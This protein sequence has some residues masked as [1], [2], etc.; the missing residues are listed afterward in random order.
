MSVV[1]GGGLAFGRGVACSLGAVCS[2]GPAASCPSLDHWLCV[3]G[4]R[5]ALPSPPH[6][7]LG[8]HFLPLLRKLKVPSWASRCQTLHLLGSSE[9]GQVGSDPGRQGADPGGALQM[10]YQAWMTNAQ[11]VLRQQQEE[12]A[13]QSPAG[14]SCPCGLG[15][16]VGLPSADQHLCAQEARASWQSHQRTQ[17]TWQVRGPPGSGSGSGWGLSWAPLQRPMPAPLAGHSHM[18]QRVLSTVQFLWVLGQALVDGLTRWLRAFTRHHRA[19]SDVLRAE[20]YLFTQELLQVS[21]VPT[22]PPLTPQPC[23]P[24]CFQTCARPAPAS[25]SDPTLRTC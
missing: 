19:I 22:A 13:G 8:A 21:D 4:S 6:G 7:A 10:A 20:R 25:P 9:G 24:A 17:R 11:T 3:V 15:V 1:A 23:L 14:E 18:M 16:G 12:R 2:L 5:A